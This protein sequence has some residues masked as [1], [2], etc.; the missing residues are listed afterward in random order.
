MP[1]ILDALHDGAEIIGGKRHTDGFH[2]FATG[3]GESRLEGI[4][5][6]HAGAVIAHDRNDLFTPLSSATL[7]IGVEVCQVVKDVRTT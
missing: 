7:A 3:I 5:G 4:F 6:V 2:H 1:R